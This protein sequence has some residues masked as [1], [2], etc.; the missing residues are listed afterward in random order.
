MDVIIFV[1]IVILL[2]LIYVLWQ[3]I[4][5]QQKSQPRLDRSLENKLL[6]MLGGDKK[7]ALRLLRHARKNNPGRSYLWYHEKVIRDLS[8]DRRY[9]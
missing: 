6:S 7:A 9:Y 8:R 1:F 3:Q 5:Q 2:S 4:R